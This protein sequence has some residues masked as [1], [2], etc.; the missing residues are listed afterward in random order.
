MKSDLKHCMLQ[1]LNYSSASLCVYSGA[2]S[3]ADMPNVPG[4]CRFE[5]ATAL[6]SGQVFV[7]FLKPSTY[8]M[9]SYSAFMTSFKDSR[10]IVTLH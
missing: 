10:Y 1:F 2:D 5:L 8:A 4:S 6:L 3:E 9:I 7:T